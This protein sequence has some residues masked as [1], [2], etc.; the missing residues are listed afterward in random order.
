MENCIKSPVKQLIMIGGHRFVRRPDSSARTAHASQEKKNE[1]AKKR[2]GRDSGA[3][4][5]Q[6]DPEKRRGQMKG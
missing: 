6:V 1:E 3:H 4:H 2:R 5:W